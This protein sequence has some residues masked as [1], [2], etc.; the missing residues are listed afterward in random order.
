[1]LCFINSKK[2]QTYNEL[3]KD[4]AKIKENVEI[5]ERNALIEYEALI[6]MP[7]DSIENKVENTS[8][9]SSEVQCCGGNSHEESSECCSE[10]K[11]SVKQQ[12][13]GTNCC[14]QKAKPV[15]KCQSKVEC[16]SEV[17]CCGKSAQDPDSSRSCFD[18]NNSKEQQRDETKCTQ[19]E[20]QSTTVKTPKTILDRF[21]R[22]IESLEKQFSH[23]IKKEIIDVEG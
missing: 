13:C 20:E 6:T 7:G 5:L 14:S 18:V 23:L 22:D 15:C 19:N 16:Q 1:M 10:E 17:E 2:T 4:L 3:K 21:Y 8:K 9:K 12:T 11:D